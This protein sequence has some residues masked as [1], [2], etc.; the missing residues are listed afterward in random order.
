MV[1]H[2]VPEVTLQFKNIKFSVDI[3]KDGQKVEK[4]ILQDISGM[5]KPGEAV[6][7]MG[8]TGGGKTSMLDA[9]A[10]KISSGSK[11]HISGEVYLNGK[12]RDQFFKR[13]AAYVQQFDAL[14][15]MLN[16]DEVL[17]YSTNLSLGPEV[18]DEEKEELIS[19]V[20]D[21]LGLD[22]VRK[23][24]IGSAI[25]PGIAAGQ[26]KRLSMAIELVTRPSVLFLDE[27]TT[28]QDAA[29]AYG[30]MALISALGK[31]KRT[32]LATI[33]QPSFAM[34]ELFDKILLLSQ[35]RLVYTGP[36]TQ[37]PDFFAK[38]GYPVPDQVNPTDHYMDVSCV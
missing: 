6:I 9:I 3:K 30:I 22:V 16:V 37:A 33:H 35:G 28:G 38:V 27:P 11:A 23:D 7:I 13:Y 2:P 19:D 26:K 25:V 17:R 21:E 18:T 34:Y 1:L 15:A 31:K 32:V 36:A 4:K 12:P 20:L 29:A 5:V 14:P 10:G 24:R 8:P